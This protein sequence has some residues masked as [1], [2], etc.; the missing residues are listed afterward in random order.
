MRRFILLVT[1]WVLGG[2]AVGISLAPPPNLYRSGLNYPDDLVPAVW[3]TAE[4]KIFYMTDRA[5]DGTTYGSDRS[6]SMAFGAA[7]VKFGR[8]LDWEE[9][10]DRTRSDSDQN[11]SSL[12][13][14]DFEEIVRF[15]ATP[16]PYA[17]SDGA[18]RHLQDAVD[19]YDAQA[20]RFQAVIADEIAQTGNRSLLVYVH[21][22]NNN[23]EDSLT[24]LANLWHFAGRESVPVSF[25]WPA[26]NGI[27]PLGYFRDRDAGV[28]SV[29]HTKEFLRM[30]AEMPE[31]DSIDIIAHSRGTDVV[32][33]ALREL[34]IEARGAGIHPK[35]ML[36]TGTFI[37][38]APDLDVDIVRQRLQAERFSEAFEQINLYINP[39]DGALRLSAFLTQSTRLGALKGED[40]IDGEL[41]LLQKE[42]LVH[43][44]RVENVRGGFGHAYF[45]D[46]P[47][48][49]SDVVLA[50]R[51]RA[52]P[53][54]TLRPLEQDEDGI[55]VLHPNYPLERLPDLVGLEARR[56]RSEE[57]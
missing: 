52:F 18:L 50:L 49:L 37:M 3:R 55:W 25:T 9:L 56:E 31:V 28:F 57:R 24:T 41:E 51:T 45:R 10:L 20:A 23:F 35:T 39:N 29:H 54:G 17:R 47:A 26:G 13:V 27:G 46:N 38:A 15:E 2:C 7:T 30:L 16:L 21:G 33:T 40:F 53:G 22:F 6:D 34:M 19:T 12:W 32:T 42:G 36:K 43:F 8:D 44:I 5:L 4:P 1:C 11:I 48:V 14:P